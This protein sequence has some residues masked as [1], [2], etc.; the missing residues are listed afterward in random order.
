MVQ[1]KLVCLI[2]RCSPDN[3]NDNSKDNH[4]QK[5]KDTNRNSNSTYNKSNNNNT[6]RYLYHYI[7]VWCTW[8]IWEYRSNR[9]MRPCY[10]FNVGGGL[11]R[12]Q[13]QP[14]TVKL[15]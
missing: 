10:L 12:S 11:F 5:V 3:Q 14:L 7:I 9:N 15:P 6:N 2:F 4:N 1:F 8:G 13:L